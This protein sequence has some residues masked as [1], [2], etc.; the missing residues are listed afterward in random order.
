MNILV[1][2]NIVWEP[3]VKIC[4]IEYNYGRKLYWSSSVPDFHSLL[5]EVGKIV[6]PRRG[7]GPLAVFYDFKL[8]MRN[9][10]IRVG[11]WVSLPCAFVRS[12][13]RKMWTPNGYQVNIWEEPEGAIYAD[14]V[15]LTSDQEITIERNSL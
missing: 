10:S 3:G 11:K 9:A 6:I 5:Y 8:A 13:D 1:S 12:K 15:M 7:Y 14:A 4:K 2:N